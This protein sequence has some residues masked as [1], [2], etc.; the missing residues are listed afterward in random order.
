MTAIVHSADGVR[1]VTT[2]GS[3][4]IVMS[5]LADYV[6]ERC[7]DVLWFDAASRVRGMLDAG[8]L[9]AAITLYFERVGER[10]DDERLE[11]VSVDHDRAGWTSQEEIV[12]N[13]R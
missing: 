9:Y 11:L 5:R 1:F 6:R 10:W 2:G 8:N 12:A 13:A 7:N 3:S 4:A